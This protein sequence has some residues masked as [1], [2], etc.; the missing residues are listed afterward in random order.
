MSGMK[1]WI[2]ADE[3]YPVYALC[4]SGLGGRGNSELTG[5]KFDITP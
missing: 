5:F 2:D 1:V 3:W 4:D